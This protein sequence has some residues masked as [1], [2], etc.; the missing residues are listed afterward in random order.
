MNI[1]VLWNITLCRLVDRDQHFRRAYCLHLQSSLGGHCSWL[2]LTYQ[3]TQC[4]IPE[5]RNTYQHQWENLESHNLCNGWDMVYFQMHL[6]ITWQN[7]IIKL[8]YWINFLI[9]EFLIKWKVAVL[10]WSHTALQMLS[11]RKRNWI[12]IRWRLLSRLWDEP[13]VWVQPFV[14]TPE[15][16]LPVIISYLL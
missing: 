8:M 16:F 2:V 5:D 6:Q 12:L 3:Y 1:S 11:Q 13:W 9:S 15:H 14:D 10:I 7:M 4:H